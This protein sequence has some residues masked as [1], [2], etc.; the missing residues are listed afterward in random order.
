MSQAACYVFLVCMLGSGG[1]A[2]HPHHADESLARQTTPLCVAV[3]RD[4]P[5]VGVV[6]NLFTYTALMHGVLAAGYYDQAAMLVRDMQRHGMTPDV[7]SINLMLSAI[8]PTRNTAAIAEIA[9]MAERGDV[10]TSFLTYYTLTVAYLVTCQPHKALELLA[11]FR[12]EGESVKDIF[13]QLYRCLHPLARSY[14]FAARIASDTLSRRIVRWLAD[15]FSEECTTEEVVMLFQ[16]TSQLG[17]L[18]L[19][20]EMLD[21]EPL[22]RH[23]T[24][25]HM[26][27]IAFGAARQAM[28]DKH[29]TVTHVDSVPRSVVLG[30]RHRLAETARFAHAVMA[31]LREAGYDCSVSSVA[32]FTQ[33]ASSSKQ[34]DLALDCLGEMQRLGYQFYRYQALLQIQRA[35]V[36]GD[37]GGVEFDCEAVGKELLFD[38]VLPQYLAGIRNIE[39]VGKL[40]KDQSFTGRRRGYVAVRRRNERDDRAA[41]SA[42]RRGGAAKTH[43][44]APDDTDFE[45]PADDDVAAASSGH[46]DAPVE[47]VDLS[48]PPGEDTD[49]SGVDSDADS[50]DDDIAALAEDDAIAVLPLEELVGAD[51]GGA[52]GSDAPAADRAGSTPDA[53]IAELVRSL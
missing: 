30:W 15:A 7:R 46:E 41:G 38:E 18:D 43:D 32:L 53:D 5:D 27:G 16:M 22:A 29:S 52:G 47:H 45:V 23:L 40:G 37:L 4:M 9:D 13:F 31:T 20:L 24:N 12:S 26:E 28:Q 14:N 25:A 19:V 48:A 36:Q 2:H 44:G 35:Y 34:F 3:Y 10:P 39:R 50:D 21:H 1:C 11:T 17:Y 33:A 49:L 42:G 51:L 6:P 8:A